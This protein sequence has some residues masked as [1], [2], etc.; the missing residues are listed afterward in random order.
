[1]GGSG[2]ASLVY[3]EANQRI[4][5]AGGALWRRVDRGQ[6]LPGDG[7]GAAKVYAGEKLGQGYLYPE[8]G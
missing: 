4:V 7:E 1:M 5:V 6:E 8:E 2:G 3:G